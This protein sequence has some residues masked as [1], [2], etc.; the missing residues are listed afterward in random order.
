MTREVTVDWFTEEAGGCL[1]FDD[2]D[3]M[4]HKEAHM[5]PQMAIDAVRACF[6]ARSIFRARGAIAML[7]KQP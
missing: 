4:A 2:Y 1:L 3:W 7:V 5:R 6:G